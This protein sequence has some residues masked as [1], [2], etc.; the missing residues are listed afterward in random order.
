MTAED[1][2][3]ALTA[4]AAQ[5]NPKRWLILVVLCLASLVLV[6]DNMVLTVALPEIAIDL[7]AGPQALQWVIDCY[8]LVFAGLLL[9]TGSLS[10]RFGRR[11][12]MVL[13]LVLFG[14]ASLL[15][16]YA[17]SAGMLISGRVIMGIGGALIMPSTLSILITVFDEVERPKAIAAWTGVSVLG[18]VGGPV[19]GGVLLNHFWWGSVFLLNVPIAAV[20]IA[21]AFALMPE[22][23]GPA[24]PTDL[25][26]MA[27]SIAGTVCLVWSI[28]EIPSKGIAG[29]WVSL[30]AAA[31]FLVAFAIRELRAEHPMVPL[32]LFSN[33]VF[34]GSRFSLVLVTFAN[35]GLSLLLTQYLQFVLGYSPIKTALAFTPLAVAALLFN[36]LGAGLVQKLG[37]R[38]V[39]L[40]GM[41]V[42]AAGS[43]AL[44]ALTADSGFWAPAPAPALAPALAM[45]VLGAGAGL[46]MPAAIGALMGAIPPEQAGVGSA[47]NDTI[48][49][50]GGA[51]GVAV[52][53]A[54]LAGTYSGAMP[55]D[56]P[57]AARDSIAG[58][59]VTGDSALVSAAREAFSHAMSTTFLAS[60]AAVLVATVIA[61]FLMKGAKAAAPEMPGAETA[62]ELVEAR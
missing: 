21:A 12:V 7:H 20:A 5:R 55:S 50:T 35:A 32:H 41:L 59:V 42:L 37:V 36:G 27:L 23:K 8:I 62:A 19:L 25:P 52:L 31:I 53:G 13:G 15:A 49:Q 24:R 11:L 29:T 30:L 47:L 56:A 26:G 46:A 9:T 40:I 6:I 2:T 10:D 28:I 58:A 38:P 60:G 43:G 61:F 39:T 18:L 4:P 51:L 48:Q 1:L 22:S 33:R 57:A 14:A 16:A 44:A 54:V 3:A 17:T 34:T 45:A